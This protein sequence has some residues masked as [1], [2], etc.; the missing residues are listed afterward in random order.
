MFV[1]KFEVKGRREVDDKL[2]DDVD[3]VMVEFEGILFQRG[4]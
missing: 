2:E 1:E 3:N 4:I